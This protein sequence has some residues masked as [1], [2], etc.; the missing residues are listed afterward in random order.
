MPAEVSDSPRVGQGSVARAWAKENASMHPADARG[1]SRGNP[2]S[3]ESDP[4]FVARMLLMAFPP[5]EMMSSDL[6]R[7][8]ALAIR[9]LGVR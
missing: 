7:L 3:S 4:D 9:G 5:D 2:I 8:C 6:R 1:F